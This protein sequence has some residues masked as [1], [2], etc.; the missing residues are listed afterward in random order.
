MEETTTQRIIKFIK[1]PLPGDKVKVYCRHHQTRYGIVSRV[2]PWPDIIN[3]QPCTIDCVLLIEC[4][5]IPTGETDYFLEE[6]RVSFAL[7]ET[8]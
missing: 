6:N 8:L 5:E 4:G 2:Y 1:T 3:K 7:K